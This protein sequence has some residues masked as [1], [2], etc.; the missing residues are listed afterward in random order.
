[1]VDHRHSRIGNI[2]INQITLK[3]NLIILGAG[4][5]GTGTALL[6][7]EK[8]YD[9]TV[10]GHIHYPKLTDDYM[11]SGDWCENCTALVE[12]SDGKWTIINYHF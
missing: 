9:V 12:N 11:N 7:K 8:G 4:E 5:S 2:R 3:K 1:M 10:C 6:G